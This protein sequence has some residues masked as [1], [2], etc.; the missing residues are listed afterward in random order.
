[1]S[2]TLTWRGATSLMVDGSPLR[3][4]RLAGL[5]PREVGAVALRVGNA[6]VPLGDLF[7]VTAGPEEPDALVLEGDLSSVAGAGRG[8]EAGRLIVRGDLG[9]HA[10]AGMRGGRMEVDGEVGDWAGAEMAE[11]V[12][13]VRGRAGDSLGGAYPGSRLGM[14]GGVILCDGSAGDRVGQSMR[15]GLVAVGGSIGTAAGHA[16]IAG[17]LFA[18][19]EIGRNPGLGMKRGTLL[20]AG[21]TGDDGLLPTFI[22]SGRLAAPFLAI[23]L[24]EL[25]SFGFAP[26]ARRIERVRRY[27]GDT[28]S[29]GRGEILVAAP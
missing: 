10:G 12:L 23:Y 3:P 17:S 21:P 18:F 1:M 13:H 15:R 4:D 9:P 20:L 11:G 19:G 7:A 6:S 5:G 22:P 14:R 2:L 27:N 28:A 25:A 29:G 8:M 24:N 26:E 16:M